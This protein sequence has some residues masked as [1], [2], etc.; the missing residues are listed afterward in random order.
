MPKNLKKEDSD[1][2]TNNINQINH[3]NITK[4]NQE[5]FQNT[6]ITKEC[7]NIYFNINAFI[8]TYFNYITE[9]NTDTE[10]IIEDIISYYKNDNKKE[11]LS[12]SDLLNILNNNG[13]IMDQMEFKRIFQIF[14]KKDESFDENDFLNMDTLKEMIE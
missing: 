2:Y 6:D 11:K 13:E 4:E 9:E 12:F 14:T 7:E 5:D 3:N 10:K 8:Y 1:S